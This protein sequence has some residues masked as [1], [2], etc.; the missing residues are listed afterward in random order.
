MNHINT[1]KFGLALGATAVLLYFGCILLMITV[2]R[3]GTV[4]FF[5]SILHGFDVAPIVRMNVP[6]GEV[7]LGIIE[8]FILG[9][10]IG[11]CIA[12]IYNFGMAKKNDK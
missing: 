8:T 3:D 11:A 4:L 6:I 7:L 1:R 5:N 9:W 10:M 12:S 2:G